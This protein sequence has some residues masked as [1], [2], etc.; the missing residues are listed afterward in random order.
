MGE[1]GYM[2]DSF[3]LFSGCRDESV[4]CHRWQASRPPS[5]APP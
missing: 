4:P 5:Q 3:P 2:L 1:A